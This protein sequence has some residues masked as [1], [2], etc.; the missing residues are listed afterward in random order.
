MKKAIIIS[1]MAL[2]CAFHMSAVTSLNTAMTSP[3]QVKTKISVSP[4]CLAIA[5]GDLV[6]VRK[7]IQLGANVNDQSNG[8]TPAMF[9]AKY[10]RVQILDLLVKY[11]ADLRTRDS[12]RMTAMDYAIKYKANDTQ[13]YLK[14]LS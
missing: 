9:A 10:N 12:K 11:G 2:S 14:N 4:F 13:E 1:A 8:M 6:T 3:T 7:L 5:Q